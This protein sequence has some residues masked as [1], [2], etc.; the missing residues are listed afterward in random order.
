MAVE[1]LLLLGRHHVNRHLSQYRHLHHDDQQIIQA[2]NG[3][4]I[5]IN[6]VT[7]NWC[8]TSLIGTHHDHHSHQI[9]TLTI[10]IFRLSQETDNIE[11]NQQDIKRRVTLHN[12]VDNIRC[13]MRSTIAGIVRPVQARVA[14][15][16][17]AIHLKLVEKRAGCQ[18]TSSWTSL[19]RRDAGQG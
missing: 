12:H 17:R 11:E 13:A 7:S 8:P 14:V 10:P 2:E 18:P 5:Q 19:T 16:P 4:R 1:T 15:M 9:T 6:Q 3:A